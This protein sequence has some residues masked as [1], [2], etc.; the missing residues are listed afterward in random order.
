MTSTNQNGRLGNQIIR[1]LAVSFIAKKHDLKVI[2]YNEKL[3]KELGID[4]YSGSIVHNRNVRLLDDNYFK[5]LN[6]KQLQH[7]FDP[8]HNFFQKC[9][10]INLIYEYLHTDE[11]KMNI[12]E[13]NPYKERYNNN[14]DLYI[15][16]RLGDIAKI[17]LNLGI[18]YYKKAIEMNHFD[19]IYIS[20]DTKNHEIIKTLLDT[21]SNA[22]LV[23]YKEINTI[24]FASTCKNII[25]SHGTFSAIIGYLSYFSTVYYPKY[26]IGGKRIWHGDGLFSIKDWIQIDL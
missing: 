6:A 25:L 19:H 20:T 22:S 2:Y 7:N 24:Q 14:N 18:E 16:V 13:C 10:I 9:T 1:N 15:H 21:Y 5:F 12:M 8:N 4:L 17:N 23:T 11:V 3:I 26:G